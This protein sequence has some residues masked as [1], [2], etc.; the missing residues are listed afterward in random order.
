M[1]IGGH[2]QRIDDDFHELGTSKA[3]Q[4]L[5]TV[6]VLC[7]HGDVK[8]CPRVHLPLIIKGR[9]L[10][11]VAEVT[12]RPPYQV[13]LGRDFPLL[14]EVVTW[15][16][17]SRQ[18]AAEVSPEPGIGK[19]LSLVTVKGSLANESHEEQE[20]EAQWSPVGEQVC[21]QDFGRDQ[22]EDKNLINTFENVVVVNG[23]GF[24]ARRG[25]IFHYEK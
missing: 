4:V 8:E 21:L 25:T 10:K 11:V 17:G 6:K 13:I 2:W 23:G 5:P 9:R 3:D 1:G 22:H 15:H 14:Q 16:G 24:T 7:I 20:M 19:D 12:S 18:V